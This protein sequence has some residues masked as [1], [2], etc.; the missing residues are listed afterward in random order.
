MRQALAEMSRGNVLALRLDWV[1]VWSGLSWTR[2][3]E[4]SPPTFESLL[5]EGLG[6]KPTVS[7]GEEDLPELKAFWEA[8][9]EHNLY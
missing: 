7:F 5:A 4:F 1:C 2:D 9:N 3:L 8:F 6:F